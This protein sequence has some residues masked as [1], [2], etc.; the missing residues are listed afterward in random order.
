MNDGY[1]S[2]ER[3]RDVFNEIEEHIERRYGIPVVIGDVTDPFTFTECLWSCRQ[4]FRRFIQRS[5]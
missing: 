3:F 2:E 1:V 5:G 4:R